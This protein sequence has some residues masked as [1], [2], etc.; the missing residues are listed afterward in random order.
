MKRQQNIGKS[1][2]DRAAA[3][4]CVGFNL[5]KASRAVGQVYDSMLAPVGLKGTQF[6]LL[7]AVSIAGQVPVGRLADTLVMERTTLTRNL[8]PLVSRG[9]L[10][11]IAGQDRRVRLIRLTS[12]GHDILDQAYPLWH[13]AQ[14]AILSGIGEK[15]RDQ[16]LK[17]LNSVS[18]AALQAHT[19]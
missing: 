13:D 10:E 11:M 16:V 9:F 14:A 5:R 12:A 3:G 2:D 6:S 4:L 1:L 8:R 18:E 19:G 15:T 17:N 7:M